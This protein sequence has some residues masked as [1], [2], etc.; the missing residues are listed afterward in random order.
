MPERVIPLVIP[1][2]IPLVI[3]PLMRRLEFLVLSSFVE[4]FV[5]SRQER[6]F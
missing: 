6:K 2:F 1:P 4:Q 5:V 3:P